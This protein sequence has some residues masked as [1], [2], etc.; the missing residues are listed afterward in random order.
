MKKLVFLI[1]LSVLLSCGKEK[2]IHLPE[3]SHSK[4]TDI[5]DVSAAYLFY[6]E[7]QKDSVELNRKNLISTTNWLVNVDKR[8]S[9]KQVIPQIKFL[10]DKK[11]NSSHKKENTKNYFTCNDT[12]RKNLGFIEFTDVVYHKE[13]SNAL[14][15]NRHEEIDSKLEI[16]INFYSNEKIHIINAS[17]EPFIIETDFKDLISELK[18]MDR[19][20]SKA[21]LNFNA[22]LKFQKYIHYKSSILNTAFNHLEISNHEFIY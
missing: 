2:I 18:K 13:S 12:S 17:S 7:A 6:D 19:P 22:S 3:I 10:Q 20:N 15:K 11:N 9:L 8:L 14:F 5:P 16:G 4:I 21:Y 1:I